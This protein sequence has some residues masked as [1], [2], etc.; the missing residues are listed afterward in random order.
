[1]SD[2]GYVY[3]TAATIVCY[4]LLRLARKS[5]DPFEPVWMF[6]TGYVHLYVVQPLSV[7][8]WALTIRGLDVVT[9][10]DQRAFWA[11]WWF[12]FIYHLAPGKPLARLAPPSPPGPRPPSSACPAPPA[13]GP[14]ARRSR[15]DS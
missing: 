4:F 14:A 3:A 2:T 9:L 1:M 7:R 12:L 8:E 11:L 5:F 13:R 10:A 6:L 15:W